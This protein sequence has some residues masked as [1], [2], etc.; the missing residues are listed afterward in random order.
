MSN[1][2]TP[3]TP[4]PGCPNCGGTGID[5]DFGP[6]CACAGWVAKYGQ[7]TTSL[8]YVGVDP[9][10]LP[11]ERVR[12]HVGGNGG[13]KSTR[14]DAASEPQIR[15]LLKLIA[16]RYES[17]VEG[18]EANDQLARIEA[19]SDHPMSKR[20][21]SEYIDALMAMTRK[22]MAAK[23]RP[24]AR[25]QACERCGAT[26]AAGAGSLAKVGGRWVVEHVGEC[27][28]KVIVGESGIPGRD[29]T[30]PIARPTVEVDLRPL[31]RFTSRG[32]V[33]VAVPGGDTR[34]KLRIKFAKDG[35]IYVDDAAV[36][37]EGAS[38]G[39]QYVGE[40]YRGKVA[41]ELAVIVADPKAAI[42]AY[43]KLV[44]KCGICNRPLEHKTS[45]EVG[46]GP[47][48]R[49][50]LGIS[51]AA[52]P[53]EAAPMFEVVGAVI[54]DTVNETIVYHADACEG[55]ECGPSGTWSCSKH[56]REYQNRYGKA[57][58]E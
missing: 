58:N 12:D 1:H 34:L 45:V 47:R 29:G 24:N 5:P 44:G 52:E 23:V 35:T 3:T 31:E 56:G 40:S 54:V 49:A 11:S 6:G 32:I 37:G 16:E 25:P 41:A 57:A 14:S 7:G 20:A 18:V 28:A 22:P 43:T 53:V 26:V 46:I 27:P 39:R 13:G 36:Y 17:G 42:L 15:F 38:Y 51:L 30:P 8:R 48:C 50:K 4:L 21:A 10:L 2:T 55:G 9:S 33:R 19:A